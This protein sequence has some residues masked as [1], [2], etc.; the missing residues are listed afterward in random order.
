V[1]G[2]LII[3]VAYLFSRQA[4]G[5]GYSHEM[6]PALPFAAVLA[7]RL[8]AGRLVSARLIPVAAAVLFGY[9][10]TLGS[11]ALEQ[12][13]PSG[14]PQ[15]ASFLAGHHLRYGLSGYWQADALTLA[16][17]NRVQIRALGVNPG[18]VSA[19][20]WESEASWYDP[21]LHDA[22][23][24]LLFSGKP[25]FTGE[26]GLRPFEPTRQIEATFGRPERT[27]DL[28]RYTVLVWRQN[29]LRRLS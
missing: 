2:T 20:H 4:L 22:N 8:L 26:A 19:S 9:V 15:V 3:V 14:D 17:G 29:L 18:S 12:P 16:S 13:A 24:V 10:V 11:N 23:F 25:G 5:I 28:G 21:R 27:Y 1:A 6:A 7:G